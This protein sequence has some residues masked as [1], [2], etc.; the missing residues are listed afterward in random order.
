MKLLY[1]EKILATDGENYIL[2]DIIPIKLTGMN[3]FGITPWADVDISA[4][5]ISTC[6]KRTENI[7]EW[8]QTAME[9]VKNY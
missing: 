5:A 7:F 6:N 8:E 3:A 1:E 9:M 4:E 2:G